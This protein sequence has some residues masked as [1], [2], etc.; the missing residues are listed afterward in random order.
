MEIYEHEQTYL[1]MCAKV[2]ET[3]WNL[4]KF[5]EMILGGA[6]VKLYRVALQ[7]RRKESP[8]TAAASQRA[9]F[10]KAMPK[11]SDQRSEEAKPQA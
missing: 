9:R 11:A 2:Y 8:E 1:D 6:H 3:C 7:K 10:Q 5:V 4:F